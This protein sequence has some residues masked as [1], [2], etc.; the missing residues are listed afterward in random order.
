MRNRL[1]DCSWSASVSMGQPRFHLSG[2]RF[3][4]EQLSLS[5]SAVSGSWLKFFVF[6]DKLPDIPI[7]SAPHVAVIST[8]SRA[9]NIAIKKVAHAFRR[10]LSE[11]GFGPGAETDI[12]KPR[13]WDS[14]CKTQY[15][16][17]LYIERPC[18]CWRG[19][20]S[21]QELFGWLEMLIPTEL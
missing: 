10:C 11:W 21:K 18:E 8:I 9:A 3:E 12:R 1:S 5:Q 6:P 15:S 19:L 16:R 17:R 2:E 14:S 4:R 20:P 7:D 13:R